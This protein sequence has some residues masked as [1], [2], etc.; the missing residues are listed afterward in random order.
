[1]QEYYMRHLIGS[2]RA[3]L[4]PQD[5][6]PLLV[7]LS[8]ALLPPPDFTASLQSL[9]DGAPS[10]RQASHALPLPL[11]VARGA[12]AVQRSCDLLATFRMLSHAL[13]DCGCLV[14]GLCHFSTVC[15]LSRFPLHKL[16]T[17][18]ESFRRVC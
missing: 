16:H 3:D 11:L 18:L 15:F 7:T 17:F 14:R 1:M 12:A 13:E 4:L 6:T 9:A 5:A 10:M 8:P 2:M